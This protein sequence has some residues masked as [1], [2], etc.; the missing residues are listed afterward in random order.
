MHRF[1]PGLAAML[2]AGSAMAQEQQ[3]VS[4]LGRLEPEHGVIRVSASSTPE[5][6]GGGLLV[7]LNVEEGD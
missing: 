3:A 4:A 7:E 5:A 1:L 2:V 6:I